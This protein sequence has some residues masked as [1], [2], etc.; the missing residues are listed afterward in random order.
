[1]VEVISHRDTV[2]RPALFATTR[3]FLD[4]LGLNSLDQLP[5]LESATS[6][7]N[8]FESGMTGEL[9]MPLESEPDLLGDNIA[10]TPSTTELTRSEDAAVHP[11][12]FPM[13][14]LTRTHNDK[15]AR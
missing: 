2:G 4:D 1:M 11:H 6:P 8:V 10:V 15:Y 12:L 3:H 9:L 7:L 13:L 14:I 5:L